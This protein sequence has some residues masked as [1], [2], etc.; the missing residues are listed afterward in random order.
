MRT[1]PDLLDETDPALPLLRGWA[2]QAADGSAA[3]RPPVDPLRAETLVALQ[4]TSRSVLGAVAYETGGVTA[5]DGL[6]RLFGSGPDRSLLGVARTVGCPL[7]GDR[8][9][10]IVVGD[11]ALGGLFALNGGRFGPSEPGGVFHL[12]AD[13][14]VWIPLGSGYADF[15]HW[16]LTGDLAE[17]YG[18]LAEFDAFAARPRPGFDE[19]YAFYPFLWTQ[20]ARDQ[21]PTLSVISAEESLRVRLELFGFAVD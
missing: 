20:E 2:E 21:R 17:L 1:L 19:T 11:D 15:V 6:V 8:P 18:P 10:I 14:T 5:A 12:P 13:D 4:V 3:L 16:C 7:D 9:D